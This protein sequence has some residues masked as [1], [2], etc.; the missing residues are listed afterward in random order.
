[1]FFFFLL[2]V[3]LYLFAFTR[4][5]SSQLNR[6]IVEH[7]VANWRRMNCVHAR[8]IFGVA[9]IFEVTWFHFA[10]QGLGRHDYCVYWSLPNHSLRK[11]YPND[12]SVWHL[13]CRTRSFTKRRQFL[14]TISLR[15][16]VNIQNSYIHIGVHWWWSQ[17]LIRIAKWGK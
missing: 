5:T 16:R 8:W 9:T 14:V 17:P 2:L 13:T 6:S 1:M 4:A 12:N 11:R 10:H 7:A 15:S 3:I